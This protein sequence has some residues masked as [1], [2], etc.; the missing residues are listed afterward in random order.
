MAANSDNQAAIAKEG[1]IAPLLQLRRHGGAVCQVEEIEVLERDVDFERAR[2]E[3]D[4]LEGARPSFWVSWT[5]RVH[6]QVVHWGHRHRRMNHYEADYLVRNE[7][8]QWR[9]A[10]V[11]VRD[12]LRVDDDEDEW[13]ALVGERD[14]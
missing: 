3:V 8:R 12:S 5:W 7:G 1:G 14:G 6:C 9:I 10:T 13:D 4:G 11:E 2:P